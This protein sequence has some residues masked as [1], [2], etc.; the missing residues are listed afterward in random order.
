VPPPIPLTPAV[1][2]DGEKTATT[3]LLAHRDREMWTDEPRSRNPP[4]NRTCEGEH[5]NTSSGKAA[6]EPC[7][8]TP[9]H[10][11]NASRACDSEHHDRLNGL[12]CTQKGG[13]KAGCQDG[14]QL[15][16]FGLRSGC[17]PRPLPPIRLG[18]GRRVQSAID[19]RVLP[20]GS[21]HASKPTPQNRAQFRIKLKGIE[22]MLQ[23]RS[24]HRAPPFLV[25]RRCGDIWVRNSLPSLPISLSPRHPLPASHLRLPWPVMPTWPRCMRP[26]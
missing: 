21:E 9:R 1:L 10:R 23:R 13:D 22:P 18:N 14:A 20:I 6:C 25:T 15:P 4:A 3:V 17:P 5:H 7:P 11:T 24:V 16:R 8:T 19:P 2:P 12:L 26:R